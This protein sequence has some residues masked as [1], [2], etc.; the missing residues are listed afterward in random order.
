MKL[1]SKHFRDQPELP[2]ERALWW[3]EWVLRNP[4]SNHLKTPANMK[5]N[6]FQSNSYDV[7]F[8]LF[9]TII[10]LVFLIRFV[11]LKVNLGL[12]KCK[13]FS[14]RFKVNKKDQ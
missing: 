13:L 3:V 8:V 2:L 12:D 14:E 4:D 9:L 5:L 10:V 6:G 7:I 1:R 11:V